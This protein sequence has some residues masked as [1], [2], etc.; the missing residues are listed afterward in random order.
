MVASLAFIVLLGMLHILRPDLAPS[1]HLISDYEV[2]PWGW[3]MRLA[4]LL[5]G[6]SCVGVLVAILSHARGI[7]GRLG[8]L[9]LLLSAGG[10]TLAG[11][12]AP[13]TTNTLHE[14]GA[15]LDQLPLAALL[16][17]ISLWRNEAWRSARGA[18]AW[19]LLALW[20]GMA[21]F[22]GA[23]VVMQPSKDRPPSPDVLVGWPSRFFI[24]THAAWLISVAWSAAQIGSARRTDSSGPV[25]AP[26]PIRRTA[27]PAR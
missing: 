2:G 18:L 17:S 27:E 22:I 10:M 4:F 26:G 3:V 7:I 21:V 16:I 25:A 5:L 20:T 14:T 24:L 15:M 19:S 23:M 9:L 1:W 8:L 13:S 11:L 6:A 12:F